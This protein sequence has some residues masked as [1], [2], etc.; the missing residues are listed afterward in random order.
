MSNLIKSQINKILK[1]GVEN[2]KQ[3][4]LILIRIIDLKTSDRFMEA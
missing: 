2:N 1:K 3:K 4:A